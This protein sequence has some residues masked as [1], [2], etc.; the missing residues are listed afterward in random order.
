[1]KFIRRY[2]LRFPRCQ[3]GV[4]AIEMAIIFPVLLLIYIATYEIIMMYSYSKRVTRVASS[5]G[6][7]VSQETNINTQYLNNFSFLAKATMFP[8]VKKNVSISVV[9]YWIDKDK[10]VSVKWKWPANT[11]DFKDSIPPS[12]IDESTFLVRSSASAEYGFH[13]F[14]SNLLPSKLSTITIDKVYYYRQRL[15]DQILC[16]NC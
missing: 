8:Y 7:I 1:M 15:G 5:V 16:S 11:P 6:D 13:V 3:D 4:A 2:F 9:G 12:M 14:S 10:R